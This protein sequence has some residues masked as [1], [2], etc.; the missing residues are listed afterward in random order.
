[1]ATKQ[2]IFTIRKW[3][4]KCNHMHYIVEIPGKTPEETPFYTVVDM[5]SDV[6]DAAVK[7]RMLNPKW[8]D[9]CHYASQYRVWTSDKEEAIHWFRG[10]TELGYMW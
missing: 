10:I 1:M 3:K 4:M 5:G 8:F 2:F 6:R 7:Y 9:I